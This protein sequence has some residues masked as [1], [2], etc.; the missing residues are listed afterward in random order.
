MRVE[1]VLAGVRA[2][3]PTRPRAGSCPAPG[4]CG[5]R[6]GRCA[7]RPRSSARQRRRSRR[8]SRSCARPP[9]TLR[10]PRGRAAPRRRAV[11]TSSLLS[12]DDVFRLGAKEPDRADQL[13]DP[14]L[15]ER[16]HLRGLSAKRTRR[17]GRLVDP[18]IGRLRRQH[19]R[20]EQ[21]ERV[22]EFEL[23]LAGSAGSQP[24]AGKIPRPRVS[25]SGAS[26]TSVEERPRAGKR[27]ERQARALRNFGRAVVLGALM[28][29]ACRRRTRVTAPPSVFRAGAAAAPQPAAARLS[30]AD[31]GAGRDQPRGR[32]RLRLDRRVAGLSAFLG[33]T[34]R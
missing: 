21:S 30:Y 28:T 8:H 13:D 10:A 9:A 3:S 16:Q 11:S 22:D 2:S 29:L 4:R 25:T 19:D 33:S 6:R 27:C 18:G 24:A 5:W 7:C 14:L 17:R 12:A 34:W 1:L 23:G 20:D 15:A 32:H 26:R 31:A